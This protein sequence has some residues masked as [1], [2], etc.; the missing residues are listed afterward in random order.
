MER[1]LRRSGKQ[2]SL[3]VIPKETHYRQTSATRIR[4]LTELKKFLK[5]NIGN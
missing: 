4:W 1:G 5:A 2:V 3:V